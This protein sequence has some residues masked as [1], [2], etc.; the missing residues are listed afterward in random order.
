MAELVSLIYIPFCLILASQMNK[1]HFGSELECKS[2][3]WVPFFAFIA[4]TAALGLKQPCSALPSFSGEWESVLTIAPS[5][6][7]VSMQSDFTVAWETD[8]LFISGRTILEDGS[9]EKQQFEV[10][11]LVGALDI[12]SDL[13]FEPDKDRFQDWVTQI[14]WTDNTWD[15]AL[16]SKITRTTDWMIAEIERKWEAVDAAFDIR[17]RA[18]SGICASAFYDAGLEVAFDWCGIET[19]VELTIDVAGFDELS[20]CLSDLAVARLD[21]ITFD[22]EWTQT[23]VGKTLKLSPA[24]VLESCWFEATAT[25]ELEGQTANAASL[26]PLSITEATVS[27]ELN[28]WDVEATGI[29]DPNQWISHIY[30]LEVETEMEIALASG[31]GLSIDLVLQWTQTLLGRA[32]FSLIYEWGDTV[33]AEIELEWDLEQNALNQLTLGVQFEWVGTT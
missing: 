10:K 23:M 8:N 7:I 29:L 19:D 4:V 33:A 14:E 11:T 9:W 18:P 30:W 16:T 22:L 13:R 3:R 27:F 20:L 25:L 15:L 21:W 31:R 2:A 17:F 12:E 6:P 24:V 26:Y 28:G 32:D 5:V 1:D